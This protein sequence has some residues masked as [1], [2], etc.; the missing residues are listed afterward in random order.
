MIAALLLVA[1]AAA[2]APTG[3]VALLPADGAVAGCTRSGRTELYPGAELYGL[4]DG[5][6]EAF[7]ELGFECATVQGYA[8]GGQEVSLEVYRMRDPTAALGVYLAKCGLETPDPALATRHTVGRLQLQLVR[9]PYYLAVT[10]EAAAA[11]LR[12]AL[13]GLAAAATGGV[14]AAPVEVLATLPREALVAG[15]ER[16]VRGPFALQA[17]VTL[18]DGDVLQLAA[19]GTTA[20]A[21]EYTGAG[22]PRFV[23][24]LAS[25]PSAAAAA[26]ALAS[27]HDRLDPY[28]TTVERAE[29]RLVFRDHAG[30]FGAVTVDG[31]RLEVLANLAAAP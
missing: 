12:A 4:I 20:V 9:G 26:A 17:L 21:G 23:R 15:S 28:L 7:L 29:R 25:Y 31:A 11:G 1:A 5:G 30:R 19:S 10:G 13:V 6:A 8:C 27:V 2:A 18:G 3:D 16:V 24:L 22:G 14:A